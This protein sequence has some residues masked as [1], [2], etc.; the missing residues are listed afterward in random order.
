MT[1]R[2]LVTGARVLTPGGEW[3][4]GWIAVE[5]RRIAAM[6]Q[7]DPPPD[8]GAG[9]GLLAADGLDFCRHHLR[10]ARRYRPHLLTEPERLSLR[11]LLRLGTALR[12]GFEEV[13]VAALETTKL[14]DPDTQWS[15]ILPYLVESERFVTT[16][17]DPGAAFMPVKTETRGRP[18]RIARPRPGLTIRREMTREGY[19]LRFSGPDASSGL[20]DEVLDEI[21]RWLSP[22]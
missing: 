3:P 4:R 16:D 13:I 22:A 1:A 20:L 14:K 9:A 12:N 17:A 11:Q 8:A 21:E 2:L 6:G 18:R 10:T 5:G 7:G 19:V 15:T